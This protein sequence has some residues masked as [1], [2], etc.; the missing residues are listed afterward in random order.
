[1]ATARVRGMGAIAPAAGFE[2]L[3]QLLAQNAT[4]VGVLPVDW[5]QLGL[6]GRQTVFLDQILDPVLDIESNQ[7]TKTIAAPFNQP[8]LTQQIRGQIA[9]IL[10][11]ATIEKVAIDQKFDDMGM[12]SLMAVEL[13]NYIRT[14]LGSSVPLDVAFDYP[15]VE[16]LVAFLTQQGSGAVA[17]EANGNGNG[18]AKNGVL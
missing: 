15:T 10:G 8:D 12:D 5:Q 2:I 18:N 6:A 1:M 9:K 11:F 7:D 16:S 4:Q 14:L 3:E 17:Y 13:S